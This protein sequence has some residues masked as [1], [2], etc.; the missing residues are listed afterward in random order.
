MGKKQN[1]EIIYDVVIGIVLGIAILFI[2]MRF[3]NIFS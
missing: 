1:K 2:I 3:I